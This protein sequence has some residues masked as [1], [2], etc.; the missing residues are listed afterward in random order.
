MAGM[1]PLPEG[2][3]VVHLAA[4]PFDVIQTLSCKTPRM[5]HSGCFNV[6]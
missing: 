1:I 4:D 2:E 3:P 6:L 5:L